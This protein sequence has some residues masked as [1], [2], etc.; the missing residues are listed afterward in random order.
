M[1]TVQCYA[2]T[3]IIYNGLWG[4]KSK[5]PCAFGSH[6][7][8]ELMSRKWN[9][10]CK[11][12]ANIPW[13]FHV[14]SL[15]HYFYLQRPLTVFAKFEKRKKEKK[16]LSCCSVSFFYF[17]PVRTYGLHIWETLSMVAPSPPRTHT[18]TDTRRVCVV[19]HIWSSLLLLIITHHYYKQV[20]SAS[21]A[22]DCLV[23]M[24]NNVNF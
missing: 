18:H 7:L 6:L 2:L 22:P 19:I 9:K 21:G 13:L 20:L 24:L 17:I 1:K 3:C 16:N 12:Q 23:T 5:L 11:K 8:P 14:A 10:W 15:S 4:R